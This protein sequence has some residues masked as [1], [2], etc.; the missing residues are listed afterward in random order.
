MREGEEIKTIKEGLD[1]E[2]REQAERGVAD[3]SS[4]EAVSVGLSEALSSKACGKK[5]MTNQEEKAI[6]IH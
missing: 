4:D 3:N 1:E 5:R 2:A 6:D